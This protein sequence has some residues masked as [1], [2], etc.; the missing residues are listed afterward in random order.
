MQWTTCDMPRNVLV[1]DAV[2]NSSLQDKELKMRLKDLENRLGEKDVFRLK[3]FMR[4]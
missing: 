2:P 1:A 4:V 3:D